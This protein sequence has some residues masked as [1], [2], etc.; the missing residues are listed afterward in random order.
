MIT[1]TRHSAL[2]RVLATSLA[3]ACLWLGARPLF[4]APDAEERSE[5]RR[6]LQRIQLEQELILAERTALMLGELEQALV[7]L[8]EESRP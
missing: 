4:A 3:L 5:R 6:S 7:T 1:K 8:R 2:A